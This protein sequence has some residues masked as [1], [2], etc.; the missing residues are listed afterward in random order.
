MNCPKYDSRLYCGLLL[1]RRRLSSA[2]NC[3]S[4][5]NFFAIWYLLFWV[6]NNSLFWDKI[7]ITFAP[8]ICTFFHTEVHSWLILHIHSVFNYKWQV[9]YNTV[10]WATSV[11]L[12]CDKMNLQ[13]RNPQTYGLQIWL[14][15]LLLE[16]N[17]AYLTRCNATQAVPSCLQPTDCCFLVTAF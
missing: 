10:I 17:I 2:M 6:Q 12:T 7:S 9:T 14:R 4:R 1:I 13:I 11:A 16:S 3:Y 15:W 5:I 8:P